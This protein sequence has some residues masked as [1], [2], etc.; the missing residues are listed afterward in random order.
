MNAGH[1]L[2][3]E[4][5]DDDEQSEP[6]EGEASE[7]QEKVTEFFR[8]YHAVV[9][10]LRDDCRALRVPAQVNDQRARRVY[11]RA[12][13]A[14]IEATLDMYAQF[15]L[16][17]HGEDVPPAERMLLEEKEAAIDA[18]GSVKIRRLKCGLNSRLRFIFK[19][20]DNYNGWDPEP[21]FTDNRWEDLQA[22]IKIRDRLTHPKLAQQLEVSDDELAAVS[23][24]QSWFDA[25][26]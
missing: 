16:L 13:F 7:H 23:R 20:V 5:E 14:E 10:P 1:W 21:K 6:E 11:V 15:L 9:Q 3:S 24:A 25:Q 22:S 26:T 12:V 19:M 17:I 18:D 2:K 4:L 8:R